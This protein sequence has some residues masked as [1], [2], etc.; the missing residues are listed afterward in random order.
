MGQATEIETGIW[1]VSSKAESVL[2][3]LGGRGDII[4]T[5]QRPLKRDG[6]AEDRHPAR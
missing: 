6:L 1:I 5:M 2:R 3:E 4:K